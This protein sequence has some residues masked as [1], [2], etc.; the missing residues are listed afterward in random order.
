[1][2]GAE[3]DV[4]ALVKMKATREAALAVR[5]AWESRRTEEADDIRLQSVARSRWPACM[6]LLR[7]LAANYQRRSEDLGIVVEVEE[8]VRLRAWLPEM[9][10]HITRSDRE[11]GTHL[12]FRM[13]RDGRTFCRIQQTKGWRQANLN[14]E[15]RAIEMSERNLRMLLRAVVQILIVH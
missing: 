12:L 9:A 4:A 14:R 7:S 1:M 10:V 8:V 6:A 2:P 15:D 3:N 5:R 11:L 13:A